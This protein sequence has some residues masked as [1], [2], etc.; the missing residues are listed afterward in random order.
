MIRSLP[1]SSVHGDFSG[2][3]LEWVAM[4]SARGSSQP[5]DRTQV[6]RIA[7][8]FFTVSHQGSPDAFLPTLF[9][10]RQ[11]LQLYEDCLACLQILLLPTKF[12]SDIFVGQLMYYIIQKY[13][14]QI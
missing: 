6:S 3:I 7:G 8:G 2:K 4:P 1:G 11:S 13:F 5:R 12:W 9:S 14:F 10:K